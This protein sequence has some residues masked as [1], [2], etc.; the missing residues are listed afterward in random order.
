MVGQPKKGGRRN[1]KQKMPCQLT[2]YTAHPDAQ[3]HVQALRVLLETRNIHTRDNGT[4]CFKG[5]AC[6]GV[7]NIMKTHIL[8]GYTQQ[9][10]VSK[11]QPSEQRKLGIDVDDAVKRAIEH[12]DYAVHLRDGYSNK[13]E[14]YARA[15]L[16]YLKKAHL[17]RICAQYPVACDRPC[18]IGTCT[19]MVCYNEITEQYVVVEIKTLGVPSSVLS[20]S[21][22][23]GHTFELYKCDATGG[24]MTYNTNPVNIARLQAHIGALLLG[25]A[26]KRP[27]TSLVLITDLCGKLHVFDEA[28]AAGE[29]MLNYNALDAI[30]KHISG[31]KTVKRRKIADYA[32]RR[33]KRRAKRHTAGIHRNK[34]TS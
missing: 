8:A 28:S 29:S 10:G 13:A 23:T 25:D 19:D 17:R 24:K 4:V 27:C 18:Y 20:P 26:L 1:K 30:R 3:E 22:S 5:M 11:V 6:S 9:S 33:A 31:K 2:T 12:K 32:E 7:H 15:I 16:Q 21:Y 14:K 34:N